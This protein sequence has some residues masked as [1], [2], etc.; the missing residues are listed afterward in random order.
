MS[1]ILELEDPSH[2]IAIA[3]RSNRPAITLASRWV[4]IK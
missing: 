2:M 3:R 1:V 4:R